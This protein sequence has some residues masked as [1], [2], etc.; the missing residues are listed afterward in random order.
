MSQKET[1][2]KLR[3]A[4]QDV[5]VSGGRVYT[6]PVGSSEPRTE[7]QNPHAPTPG[8]YEASVRNIMNGVAGKPP[9]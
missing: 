7:V 6:R 1:I 5:V 3:A 9:R 2:A 8:S 4:G